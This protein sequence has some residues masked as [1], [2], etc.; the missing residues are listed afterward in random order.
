MLVI[1]LKLV[2]DVIKSPNQPCI[3][4]QNKRQVCGHC[5]A[6]LLPVVSINYAVCCFDGQLGSFHCGIVTFD[7][8]T[9]QVQRPTASRIRNT[10]GLGIM[11]LQGDNGQDPDCAK[12]WTSYCYTK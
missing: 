2:S 9:C 8:V 3:D 6:N 7:C 10:G 11:C 4:W 5:E 1:R 12:H